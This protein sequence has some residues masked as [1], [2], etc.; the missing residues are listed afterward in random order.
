MILFRLLLFCYCCCCCCCWYHFWRRRLYLTFCC[1]PRQAEGVGGGGSTEAAADIGMCDTKTRELCESRGGC[2]FNFV[3]A[4]ILLT[5]LN[6]QSACQH[7]SVQDG[8]YAFEKSRMRSWR[9]LEQL[10]RRSD[11]RWPPLHVRSW[12]DFHRA[13]PPLSVPL[14]F[15]GDRCWGDFGFVSVRRYNVA[16]WSALQ[17]FRDA[18]QFLSW[19]PFTAR[20][21]AQSFLSRHVSS[22][23]C[24]PSNALCD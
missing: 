12:Y 19:M 21:S 4:W 7:S 5:Q 14:S 16:S 24:H 10:Q 18:A 9:L 6:T 2:P 3:C 20:L 8:V 15:T 1:F 17:V 23:S 13:I 11:L 22:L